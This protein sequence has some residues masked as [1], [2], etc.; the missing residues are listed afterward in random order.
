MTLLL[1]NR[2]PLPS[3][4]TSRTEETEIRGGA[5]KFS[6]AA[7]RRRRHRTP[8]PPPHLHVVATAAPARRRTSPPHFTAVRP[9]ASATDLAGRASAPSVSPAGHAAAPRPR[10]SP[11]AGMLPGVHGV[12]IFFF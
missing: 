12:P 5:A 3:P 11:T 2:G 9:R 4:N 8:S 7:V 10:T 1:Y 6:G